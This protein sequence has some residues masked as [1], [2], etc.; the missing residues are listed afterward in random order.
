MRA[1]P[2]VL[3]GAVASCL[4][5]FTLAAPPARA[6]SAVRVA[7]LFSRPTPPAAID[8]EDGGERGP[9]VGALVMRIERMEKEIRSLTG[10]I[11]QLQFQTRKL[12]ERAAAAA[13]AVAAPVAHPSAPVAN[14]HA[15][16]QVAPAQVAPAQPLDLNGGRMRRSDAFDPSSNPGAPGAP[17]PLGST[18]PSAPLTATPAPARHA[19]PAPTGPLGAGAPVEPVAPAPISPNPAQPLDLARPGTQPAEVAAVTPVAPAQPTPKEEYDAALAL[20]RQGQYDSAEKSLSGFLARHPKSRYTADATF[21]LGETY[22]QR[23]RHREAAENYLKITTTYSSAAKAPEALL[24]LG[25]SL[26]ALGAKEQACASF[27]EVARKY[28][29]ASAT[30]RASADREAKKAQC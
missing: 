28:P 15:P 25:Q 23:S 29:N 18:P 13:P 4:A 9:D 30:V 17:R 6:E 7:Q 12:E 10:Q 24:R 26:N 21:N 1:F 27:A 19:G 11:E 14:V 16:A 3:S 22:F 8:D 5:V 20:L 2:L